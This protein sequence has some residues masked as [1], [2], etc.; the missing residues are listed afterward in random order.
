MRVQSE[1]NMCHI[2]GCDEPCHILHRLIPG[3]WN[4]WR[5][6]WDDDSVAQPIPVNTVGMQSGVV[7]GG[8]PNILEIDGRDYGLMPDVLI[9][10]Q[11]GVRRELTSLVTGQQFFSNVRKDKADR[12]T[13]SVVIRP[14]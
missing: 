12:S 3:K 13:K 7:T 14:Q 9:V 2:L 10:D 4:V 11:K 8:K 6:F 1:K 5:R